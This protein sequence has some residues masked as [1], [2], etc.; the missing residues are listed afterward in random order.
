LATNK[1]IL[2]IS[3]LPKRAKRKKKRK[4]KRRKRKNPDLIKVPKK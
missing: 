2:A 3:R 1:R 4:K